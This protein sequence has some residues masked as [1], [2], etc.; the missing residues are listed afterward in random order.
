MKNIK[1][2]HTL[3]DSTLLQRYKV[4]AAKTGTS[5]QALINLVLSG[6]IDGIEKRT[7]DNLS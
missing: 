4:V 5:L 1:T 2:T 3:V 7:K 6:A